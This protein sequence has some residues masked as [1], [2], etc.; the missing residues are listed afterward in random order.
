MGATQL[1]TALSLV[2]GLPLSSTAHEV[3]WAANLAHRVAQQVVDVAH[4]LAAAAYGIRK[5]DLAVWAAEQGLLAC[6]QAESL[7]RDLM[8][9]TAARGDMDRLP[10][11]MARLRRV[12]SQDITCHDTDDWLA[13]P[14]TLSLYRRLQAL[15]STRTAVPESS[16]SLRKLLVG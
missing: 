14:E 13:A 3:T 4:G 7:Y 16:G 5:Y 2:R 10:G 8:R 6:R 12:V 11:G 1:R 9:T 15:P